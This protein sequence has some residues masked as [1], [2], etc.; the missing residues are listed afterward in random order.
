MRAGMRLF[1]LFVITGISFLLGSCKKYQEADEAFYLQPGPISVST[2]TAQGSSSH[3]ITD[4]WVYV[5]GQFQ[6]AYPS[7]HTIPIVSK[8]K[9]VKLDI[10]AGIKNNGISGTRIFWPFYERIKI[11]TLVTVGKTIT[12]PLTFTYNSTTN[13]SWNESFDGLGTTLESSPKYSTVSGDLA[14]EGKSMLVTLRGDSTVAMLK[15]TSSFKL[16]TGSSNVYLELNYKC[17]ETIEIGLIGDNSDEKSAFFLNPSKQW[18]KIYINLAATVN[19]QVV[20]SKYKV[21]IRML[22]IESS[23]PEL[24]LDNIKLVYLPP[25]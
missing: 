17:N 1:L 11:D 8:G 15:S 25:Q 7:D 4:L 14:F 12:R 18:N 2:T 10:Y 3:K 23:E 19:A 22:K 20:S 5:N 9:A 24:Y 16:P 13:F 21:F 6:G